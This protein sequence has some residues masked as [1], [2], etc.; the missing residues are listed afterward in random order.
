MAE[1]ANNSGDQAVALILRLVGDPQNAKAA[2]EVADTIKKARE[3]AAAAGATVMQREAAANAKLG[4]DAVAVD[5][6]VTRNRIRLVAQIQQARDKAAEDAKRAEEKTAANAEKAAEREEKANKRA[7]VA[8]E[9]EAKRAADAAQRESDRAA[10]AAERDSERKAKAAER[11]AATAEKAAQKEADRATAAKQREAASVSELN[12]RVAA[13][14]RASDLA[15]AERSA[16]A[17]LQSIKNQQDVAAA[18][19]RAGAVRV[20]A[21]NKFREAALNAGRGALDAVKGA[22]L[23][24]IAGQEDMQK[25]IQLFAQIEGGY[26]LVKGLSD[27][28]YK[29]REA[30]LAYRAAVAAATAQQVALTAATAA[31]SAA[32][33]AGGVGGLGRGLMAGAGG[34]LGAL[35]GAALLW[36][37]LDVGKG[38][39]D[40]R[41]SGHIAQ[42]IGGLGEITGLMRSFGALESATKAQTE[43]AKAFVAFA[44]MQLKNQQGL[45]DA[46]NNQISGAVG[47]RSR[48]SSAGRLSDDGLVALASQDV[49]SAEG[50]V[51]DAQKFRSSFRGA[52]RDQMLAADKVESSALGELQAAYERQADAQQKIVDARKAA[53]DLAERDVETSRR[54]VE[55]A[56]KRVAVEMK[57]VT[58]RQAAF[59]ALSK[60][61][62]DQLRQISERAKSGA[63]TE[64]DARELQRLGFGADI[65]RDFFAQKG[66]AAGADDVLGALGELSGLGD[67]EAE[68]A[69]AR[70]QRKEA[71]ENAKKSTEEYTSAVDNLIPVLAK[72]ELVINQIAAVNVR[73]QAGDGPRPAASGLG[74]GTRRR[75]YEN[76]NS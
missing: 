69:Q 34:T 50:R 9:K 27:L 64:R 12:R 62:Q 33:A 65:S 74:E 26:Q 60:Q 19:E 54:Q 73:G 38:S 3:A 31:G 67:A 32:S 7:A 41:K 66:T 46:R 15:A 40:V 42:G 53:V 72:L 20:A 52:D 61:Q 18:A 25:F 17:A 23:L 5:E 30:V 11:A 70:A 6:K 48:L 13:D 37:A 16:D 14:E 44:D 75:S 63:T 4:S 39:S 58:E 35:G 1:G 59:G 51:A 24:G 68:L 2:V 55:Q 21:E 57:G 29:G 8:A 36:A 47:I 56:E 22:A 43:A 10:K 76:G 71:E 45:Q 28:W 49:T